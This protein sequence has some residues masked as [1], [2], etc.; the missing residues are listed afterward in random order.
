MKFKKINKK[1]LLIEINNLKIIQN[2]F[3]KKYNVDDIFSNSK[4]FE[5]TIANK[6]NHILIP[7][8]SGS[9]DAKDSLDN[10]YEYKHYKRTSSNHSWTFNDYSENTINKLKEIKSV[11]F[12]HINDTG[13]QFIFDWYYEVD[14]KIISTYLEE[15]TKLVKNNRKMINVSSTQIEKFL[16]IRKT[17]TDQQVSNNLYGNDLGSIYKAIANIERITGVKNILTSNKIWEVLTSIHLNHNVNSEQGGRVGA[18]DAF[19]ANNNQYEYKISKNPNWNFQDISENVLSK[20]NNIKY[21]ILAIK[22]ISNISINRIYFVKVKE[23]LQRIRI[24]L[25]EKKERKQGILRRLQISISLSDIKNITE[26][27]INIT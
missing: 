17:F 6:L 21:F 8:H 22:N 10:I 12:A 27:V 1:K 5:I 4:I 13:N 19:D 2:I 23:L 15:K 9:R 11:I 7:G 16:S 3:L 14:G 20:Y 26:K 18:H 24:K 25:Q